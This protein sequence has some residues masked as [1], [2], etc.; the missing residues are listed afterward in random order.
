[1]AYERTPQSIRGY[2]IFKAL[3]TLILI[4]IILILLLRGCRGATPTPSTP[5][6]V[7][8]PTATPKVAPSTVAAPTLSA[9]QVGMDGTVT[10]SGTGMPGSK[11]E[12]WAGGKRIG[13]TTV[14][15]DG[16]WSF[17]A[18][19]DPGDYD[20]TVRAVDA[21]GKTLAESAPLKFTVPALVKA[22]TLEAPK[23][24]DDGTVTLSGTGTP[25]SKVELWAGGKRIGA[26]TV[27]AD[28]TWSFAAPSM[29]AGDYDFSARAVDAS[30]KTLA[31]SA[32]LKFT[33][34]ALV[35]TPTLDMP[36]VGDD[37]ALTLS[38]TGTP[39]SKVEIWAGGKRIGEATVG[40]DGKWSFVAPSM[41][42][43]DYDFSAR[44]VD[45]S[46]KT[47]AESAPLKFIVPVLVKAPTLETPKMGD[48]GAVTLS[49]TGTPG[50]KVELWAGGKRIGEAT[51][52]ADGK[53]SFVAPS[54]EAGDYDFSARAVDASGKT[55]AESTPLKFTVPVLVKA[56]TLTAPLPD[57]AIT[58]DTVTL[59]G[60]GEPGAEIEIL[61]NGKVVGKAVVQADGT[62]KFDDKVEPGAHALAVQNAGDA[63]SASAAINVQVAAA[64][65][66]APATGVC[67]AGNIPMGI[68]QGTT[69]VV[70]RCEY[71]GLIAQRTG[72]KLADLI[73][74]NP[75]VTNPSLIYPDQVLNLPPR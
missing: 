61:D 19:L 57:A 43:G 9:P 10:L 48:D 5:T 38:G 32:P 34:P 20:F 50:S 53:W 22:P 47:L 17:A 24:G 73:A 55:L 60:T 6:A 30:G 58:G 66:P 33:V 8:P 46:G 37:G 51:V 64:P 67:S 21:S 75:Q 25:G 27:G 54:M 16:T 59:E 4:L 41:E 35:K 63:A 69:Y 42:A 65:K 62:W 2:N 44:A 12:I 68:D 71:M 45:A 13:A 28:G 15:A 36:K 26:A 40:A 14:G 74:A 18:P 49:G 7:T 72:V 1:M 3:V 23:V 56:P 52:G 70:A 29:E 11:V 39:G 31:E